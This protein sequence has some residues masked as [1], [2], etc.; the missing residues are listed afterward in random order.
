[1]LPEQTGT[2]KSGNS[3][4]G[5]AKKSDNMTTIITCSVIGGIIVV[6][7]IGL[8]IFRKIKLKVRIQITNY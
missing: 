6:S 3:N 5:G 2:S 1:L 8:C 4:S 7:I